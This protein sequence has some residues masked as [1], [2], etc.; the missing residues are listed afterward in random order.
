MD[1]KNGQT[2]YTSRRKSVA[3]KSK[4]VVHKTDQKEWGLLNRGDDFCFNDTAMDKREY[5]GRKNH[6]YKKSLHQQ[7]YDRLTSMQAFGSSK[8]KAKED[9]TM[10]D[11]IFSYATYETYKKHCNYYLHWLREVTTLK[12]AKKYAGEWLA[13]RANQ[14]G[15]NGRSLSAWTIHTEA[16]AIAKLFGI[17]KADLNRFIPPKRERTRIERSRITTQKDRHFSVTNNAEL[18]SFCRGTGCRRNV[19]ERLEG[20]DWWT[21][22]RMQKQ[23]NELTELAKAR[24]LS[25]K[26]KT[27]V[28]NL[29]TA[30]HT[31]P[32]EEDFLHHRRDKGGKDRFAPIIGPQKEKNEIIRRLKETPEEEKV[33]THVSSAADVHGYRSDYASRMYRKYARDIRDIPFDRT[34]R[35]NGRRYQSEVY[36]CRKDERGRKLDR[37]AMLTC[38]IAL[39][40][41]RVSVVA[42]HYLRGI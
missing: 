12:A 28:E 31:F 17:D 6:K 19:L 2:A 37:K 29:R 36:H 42:E 16:A 27:L 22:D 40:H 34:N 33:W 7:A 3:R 21:R 23:L 24:K 38:S 15:K 13:Q 32:G 1:G 25:D 18:I 14:I 35:G 10:R 11:K 26:E 4:A 39:G 9:G 30:L 5:M 41:N 20:R 8:K